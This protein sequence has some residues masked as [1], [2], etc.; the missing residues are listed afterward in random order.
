[1]VL[2]HLDG[3]SA[4]VQVPVKF[5][6]DPE[7]RLNLSYRFASRDL[8]LGDDGV[9][10][11]LSFGGLPFRCVLPYAAIYA[12]T[13]HVTGEALVWPD[14][15]PLDVVAAEPMPQPL[16]AEVGAELPGASGTASPGTSDDEKAPATAVARSRSHLRLIK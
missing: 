12:V 8:T 6:A 5:A 9:C 15:L 16:L 3:R 11:T 14:D 7:L 1:M 10:C 2:V 13:S 4:G